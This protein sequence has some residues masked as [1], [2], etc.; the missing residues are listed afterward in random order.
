[1]LVGATPW[2]SRLPHRHTAANYQE[3]VDQVTGHLQTFEH[4]HLA[5]VEVTGTP[6]VTWQPLTPT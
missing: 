4:V 2:C 1:M 6:P 5:I 3:F